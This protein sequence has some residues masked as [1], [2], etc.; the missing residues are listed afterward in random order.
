MKTEVVELATKIYIITPHMFTR[1]KYAPV[2][3]DNGQTG[4]VHFLYCGADSDGV[5]CLEMEKADGIPRDAVGERWRKPPGQAHTTGR[6]SECGEIAVDY[7][8]ISIEQQAIPRLR[9]LKSHETGF[10]SVI[11]PPSRIERSDSRDV[12]CPKTSLEGQEYVFCHGDL[13]R[14]NTL[15]DSKSLMN[16]PSNCLVHDTGITW[17]NSGDGAVTVPSPSYHCSPG[18]IRFLAHLVRT[19]E[20]RL[21]VCGPLFSMQTRSKRSLDVSPEPRSGQIIALD[22]DVAGSSRADLGPLS[23]G[24]S[25]SDRSG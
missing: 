4:P 6:C 8:T 9:Q 22:K 15:R 16:H 10:S 1:G 25:L 13:S 19:H 20:T 3:K 17:F 14:S 5:M 23:S 21:F 18:I 11:V 2:K 24:S 12:W 7:A